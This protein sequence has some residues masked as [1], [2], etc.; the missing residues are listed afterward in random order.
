M[1]DWPGSR[2]HD[3]SPHKQPYGLDTVAYFAG[4]HV[5]FIGKRSVLS[6]VLPR[7]KKLLRDT[8]SC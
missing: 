2:C 8:S 7:E 6:C 5:K 4:S 3:P 1:V